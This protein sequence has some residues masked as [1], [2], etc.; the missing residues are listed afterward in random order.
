[1][2]TVKEALL[3][4]V[5]AAIVG[6]G[7]NAIRNS[8]G[9]NGLPMDTPWP[10]NRKIEELEFPPSYDPQTDS[11][12]NLEEAYNLYLS[13]AV[14]IDAREPEEYDEGHIK[15]A[16]NLPFEWWDNFWPA[17]EPELNKADTIV[18][19]CGGLDCEL[20]LFA[21]RNLKSLG[22]TESYIFFGGWQKWEENSLPTEKTED[23]GE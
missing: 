5:L 1:M 3:I 6:F 4:I 22:Y 13:G 23:T 16:I 21:A 12:V 7:V 2:K 19:Y 9:W 18:A 8:A 10:D 11:L 15:G 20:S 17:V 14:F